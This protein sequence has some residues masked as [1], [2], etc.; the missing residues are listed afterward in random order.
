M[1]TDVT[2][3]HPSCVI[4]I[5]IIDHVRLLSLSSC[6]MIITIMIVIGKSESGPCST[7][8]PSKSFS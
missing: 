5:V 8:W 2:S 1:S 6:V 3:C 7:V 4:L